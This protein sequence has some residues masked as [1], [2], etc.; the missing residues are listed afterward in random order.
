M[1]RFLLAAV[2]NLSLASP[3][4]AQGAATPDLSGTWVLNLEK[5]KMP[6]Q[7]TIVSETIV[8]TCSDTAIQFRYTTNGKKYMKTIVPNGKEYPA[9]I[10]QEDLETFTRATWEKSD[11]VIEGISRSAINHHVISR[12]IMR[13]VLSPDGRTLSWQAD[14]IKSLTQVYDKQ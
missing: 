1:R 8:I 10:W 12:V 5:S 14:Q 11:L 7:G 2:L 13:W 3:I 6:Q 4:L 9:A